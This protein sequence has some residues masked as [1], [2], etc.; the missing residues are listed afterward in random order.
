MFET[1]IISHR[2]ET[3]DEIGTARLTRRK[4][5]VLDAVD[6]ELGCGSV[7]SY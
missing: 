3:R 5:Q 6:H 2:G 1:E 7:F 4:A